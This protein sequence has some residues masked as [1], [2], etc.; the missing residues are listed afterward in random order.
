MY[1]N[2]HGHWS[3]FGNP[4]IPRPMGSVIL[5]NEELKQTV[6]ADVKDFFTSAKWYREM[7]IPYRRGYLLYGYP[8]CGKSSFIFA[9]AGELKMNICLLNLSDPNLT[10]DQLN[11]LLNSVPTRSLILLEDVD[12]AFVDRSS[13][14]S[15]SLTFS[16]LLNSLG[17]HSKLLLN[18]Y[19]WCCC[20]RRPSF[21][22]D[23]QQ[24]GEIRLCSHQTRPS[25]YDDSF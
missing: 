21:I 22:Y 25:G 8:G 13:E 9:L 18:S 15:S 20:S 2:S 24:N 3:R 10:D 17:N 5:H 23:H 1:T 12:A 16:G 11:S 14:S 19:R 4:R 7:G 6:V